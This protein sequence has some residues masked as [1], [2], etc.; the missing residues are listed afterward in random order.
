M[1]VTDYLA[2]TKDFSHDCVWCSIHPLHG[3]FYRLDTKGDS[4]RH[5]MIMTKAGVPYLTRPVAPSCSLD[6]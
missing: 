5:L 1:A 3:A 6:W 2:R 4:F